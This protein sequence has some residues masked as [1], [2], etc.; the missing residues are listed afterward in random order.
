MTKK[1]RYRRMLVAVGLVA[2]PA[3]GCVGRE[4]VDD[5]VDSGGSLVSE[6]GQIAFTHATKFNWT[7]WASS[8]ADI[9]L[10]NVDGSGERR[11]TNSPGLDGFPA[12]SSDG[13]RLAFSS[14][15]DR[16]NS[17]I[18]VM[19]A[20]GSGQRRLTHTPEA[21]FYF[22]WSPDGERIAYTTYDSDYNAKIWVMDANGSDRKQ[23]ASGSLP[24]WSPNG[25]RI[26]YT[27][28]SGERPYLAV[29]NADGSEQR[30]LGDASLV[31]RLTGTAAAEE[32]PAWSPGGERIAFASM[33]D[34]EIYAM[35]V[36]GS[37]RTR[38][39]DTP[40]YDHWPPTWSPDGTRIAFTS[41]DSKGS[42]IYVMNSDGSGLTNLTDE[43][44][45]EDFYPAWRP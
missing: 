16:G 24:S 9:Y 27:A 2:A 23:L 35:K 11:L 38:L 42:D 29:M 4:P 20:D 5:A 33:D 41:E 18:Y 31:R 34:G 3:W 22:S 10:I 15:R 7:N 26:A 37:R 19:D 12:W 36:D 30:R 45:A 17:E 44:A 21:E 8:E 14:A 1:Y 43:S 13:E 25:E 28:Y 39:T 40:G 6:E 32:Q